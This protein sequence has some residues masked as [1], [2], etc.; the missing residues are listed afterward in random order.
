VAAGAG[1]DPAAERRVFETLRE[2][3]EGKAVGAKLV[4]ERLLFF[5]IM[6]A[7]SFFMSWRLRFRYGSRDLSAADQDGGADEQAYP[8]Q[9]GGTGS[10]HNS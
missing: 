2:V 3:A 4:F 10:G 7:V 8:T 6:F 1:G 5:L 9:H